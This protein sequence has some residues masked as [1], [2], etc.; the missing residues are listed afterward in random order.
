[1]EV[2]HLDFQ[3]ASDSANHRFTDQNVKAFAAGAEGNNWIE[4]SLKAE[5]LG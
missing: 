4:R 2:C 5:L 3:I 1:M